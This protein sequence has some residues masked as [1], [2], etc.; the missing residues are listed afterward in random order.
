MSR[1]SEHVPGSPAAMPLPPPPGSPD[2]EVD[3]VVTTRDD[4][5]GLSSLLGRLPRQGIHELFIVDRGSTD[6]GALRMLDRIE[7]GGYH[8]LRQDNRGLSRARNEGARVSRAPFVLYLDVGMVLLDGILAEASTLLNDDSTLAAVLA[9][10]RWQDSGEPI[11]VS[12]VDPA[13]IVA[14]VRFEPFAVLRRAAIEKVGGWDEQLETGPDRDFFLSLVETGW[15]FATLPLVGFV[16]SD[17]PGGLIAPAHPVIRDDNVRI[18]EKHREL[19]AAHLTAIVGGYESAMSDAVSARSAS[20]EER[21]VHDLMDQLAAVRADLAR[22]EADGVRARDI[23]ADVDAVRLEA[24]RRSEEALTVLRERIAHLDREI[25]A[26]HA[27][28]SQ[29]LVR[30]LRHPTTVVRNEDPPK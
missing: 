24:E 2:C 16:R 23:I 21:T 15:S 30:A 14:E 8:V 12:G 19:Y 27:T 18:V 11:A 9:D 13:S 6:I 4:G 1:P 5:P 28:K 29:R 22:S 3:V 25:V 10:G 26:I 20:D 7:A 17:D